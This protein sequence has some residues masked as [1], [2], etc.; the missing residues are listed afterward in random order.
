[1][2]RGKRPSIDPKQGIRQTIEGI[3]SGKSRQNLDKALEIERLLQMGK[4]YKEIIEKA[5]VGYETYW[6]YVHPEF[7][8]RNNGYRRDYMNA[9]NRAKLD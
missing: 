3:E 4:N 7:H 1:M 6:K 2:A 9:Y 8:D 5:D